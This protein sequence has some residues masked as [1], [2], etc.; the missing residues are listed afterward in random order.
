MLPSPGMMPQ[1]GKECESLTTAAS[2]AD[3]VP[4]EVEAEMLE[5]G[6][7]CSEVC[8]EM[9]QAL[10]SDLVTTTQKSEH[11]P[12][13]RDMMMMEASK[14]RCCWHALWHH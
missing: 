13:H 2:E 6:S 14:R 12:T 7:M 11:A 10:I 5:R 1:L 8:G 3:L 9:S 4:V